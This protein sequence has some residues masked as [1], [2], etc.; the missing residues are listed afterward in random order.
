MNENHYET[1]LIK[2]TPIAKKKRK[3]SLLRLVKK[4]HK[5]LKKQQVDNY[6]K[7][8]WT[9]TIEHRAIFRASK[10]VIHRLE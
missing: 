7:R 5:E 2:E 8:G 9:F 3:T 4:R 6:K 10:I 1:K